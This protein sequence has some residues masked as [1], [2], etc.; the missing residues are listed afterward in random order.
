MTT[1][2]MARLADYATL[3]KPRIAVM[4]LVVVAAGYALGRSEVGVAA[5]LVHALI[6]IALVA[7]SSSALNQVFERV[8]DGLMKRTVNRPLPAGRL[9]SGEALT[10]GAVCGVAGV[11]YLLAFVN[12]PTAVWSGIT[13]V[14]YAFVYTPLKRVL[15]LA[16]AIGAIPGAMPPV[17]G[18]LAAGRSIDVGAFALFGILFLWQ[19]PHFL[20]IAWI[21]RE[22]Y[23]RA[24]LK[25]LPTRTEIP[26]VTGTLAFAYSVALLPISLL[27]AFCGLAGRTYLV[28][29]LLLS[30]WYLVA[31]LR[32]AFSEERDS[33]R[34]VLR[35]SLVYLPALLALLVWDHYRLLG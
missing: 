31:S 9:S 12:Q 27:P 11:G 28:G 13:L 10:F 19:F 6:G 21:Y 33:A 26:R 22:D 2:L 14:L 23:A 25:M 34:V 16:T 24:G 5:P 18:W 20:A 32:F 17:L 30:L 7:I 3:G 35:T 8:T 15:P 4:S 1:R 29:A